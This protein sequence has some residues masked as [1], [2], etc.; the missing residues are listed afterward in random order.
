MKKSSYVKR[1]CIFLTFMLAIAP[2]LAGMITYKC[3]VNKKDAVFKQ[4]EKIIFTAR[5]LEDGKTVSRPLHLRYILYHDHKIVKDGLI[6]ADRDI[7]L[8]TSL[9]RPGWVFLQLF[10][11][12]EYKD[13]NVIKKRQ[14][15]QTIIKNG[16]KRTVKASGGIGAMVSPE[17]ITPGMKEPADFDEFWNNAKKELAA[18]PV[19]LIE[20]KPVPQNIIVKAGIKNP[21]KYIF[22]DIKIQC[23]GGMPVSGYLTM[24]K[25][26]EKGSLPAIVTYHGAGVRSANL[27]AGDIANDIIVLDVN[28]HGIE[29]GKP[30]E[31]YT[32]LRKNHYYTTLDVKRQK[33]YLRWNRDDRNKYYM[34]GMFLRVLRAL[35]YVKSLPEWDGKHL[36]VSGTSQGGTQSIV[37]AALD[38]D[39]SFARAGV[40]GW[41]D[42]SGVLADRRSGGGNIYSLEEVRANP[43]LAKESSYFD[44]MFFA[45]RIKC[46]IY[47]NTGFTDTVCAPSSIFATYNQ[48]PSTTKKHMQTVPDFGHNA[49]HN[50]GR[51]AIREYLQ[52]IIK[53]EK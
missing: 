33:N 12:E 26:A 42:I 15:F 30:E 37:A 10:A 50:L 24:P 43:E 5:M 14:V 8:E 19:K 17:Q 1:L 36:L 3:T 21:E 49:D 7:A 16:K 35:E 38:K 28:A 32:D 34:R 51:L 13:G 6:K 44:C 52:S 23:A 41:C 2:A 25:N 46:P 39:V 9:D 27:H 11:V 48:I 31:F 22:S 40:P 45:R 18:V 4:G 20:S 47:I 53:K 29:N